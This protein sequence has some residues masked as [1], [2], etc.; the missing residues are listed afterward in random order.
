MQQPKI[1]QK[2][3]HSKEKRQKMKQSGERMTK[4]IGEE[5]RHLYTLEG[6]FHPKTNQK[7]TLEHHSMMRYDT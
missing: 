1:K 6:I 5:M 3:Q 2:T 4:N 7:D